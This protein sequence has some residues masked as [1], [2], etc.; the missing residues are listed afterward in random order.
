MALQIGWYFKRKTKLPV[1]TI[2]KLLT[3]RILDISI[4]FHINKT[5]GCSQI[6]SLAQIQNLENKS[7]EIIKL[8]SQFKENDFYKTVP[9]K[10]K[11]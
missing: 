3:M 5:Y 8:K 6:Y 9:R 7:T 2:R 1:R 4:I 10:P 11:E